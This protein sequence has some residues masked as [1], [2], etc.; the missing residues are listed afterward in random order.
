MREAQ[1]LRVVYMFR[2]RLIPAPPHHKREEDIA[3]RGMKLLGRLQ[4]RQQQLNGPQPCPLW[5][6]RAK[7]HNSGQGSPTNNKDFVVLASVLLPNPIA[8]VGSRTAA[9]GQLAPSFAPKFASHRRSSPCWAAV[10][11]TSELQG[12]S[13]GFPFLTH[14]ICPD[15]KGVFG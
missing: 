6:Y 12:N 8:Q 2:H 7:R 10:G 14:K 1:S 15:H 9:K 3:L 13:G 5:L 4:P 11:Q